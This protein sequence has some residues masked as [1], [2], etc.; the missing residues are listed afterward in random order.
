V[1][2]PFLLARRRTVGTA[3]RPR[4]VTRRVFDR[5]DN[6]AKQHAG[7]LKASTAETTRSPSV[8]EE[9]GESSFF[10]SHQRPYLSPLRAD[11]LTNG[12]L[13]KVG[14]SI[15]PLQP[16]RQHG[17]C[18]HRARCADEAAE[19]HKRGPTPNSKLLAMSVQECPAG[20]VVPHWC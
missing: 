11:C 16:H 17:A 3:E 13:A 8:D 7:R 19:C 4:S 9:Q 10:L 15:L 2:R 18:L 14:L 20:P 5:G 12:D 1:E 6:R